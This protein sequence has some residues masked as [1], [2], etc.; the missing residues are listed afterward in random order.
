MNELTAVV[1]GATGLTG[2]LV[3]E[4]LLKDEN[5]VTVRVLT[6]RK[7]NRSHPKLQQEIVN[8][9]D[10]DDYT[11]K[12]GEGDVIFSCVGTTQKKVKGNKTLYED[13]D[14]GIPVNAA[15]IGISKNYKKFLVVSAIGANENASNFYLKLKGKTEKALKEIPFVSLSIF[16]PSLINGKRNENRTGEAIAQTV[17]DLLSFLL[18]GPLE[19]YRSIGANNIARAMVN[20]SKQKKTGVNYYRYNEMMDLARLSL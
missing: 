19:K 16:Q 8:F 10:M 1:L 15:K 3:L 7:I 11:Q 6:R 9:N 12:F 20:E 13:I 17:M 2:N 5:F 18:L 4:E 14:F